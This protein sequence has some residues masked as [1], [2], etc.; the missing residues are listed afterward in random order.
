MMRVVL[1]FMQDLTAQRHRLQVPPTIAPHSGLMDILC[2][3]W[4]AP[5]AAPEMQYEAAHDRDGLIPVLL[6]ATDEEP[7]PGRL[8]VWAP[9]P[10]PVPAALEMLS[11]QALALPY[12]GV[13]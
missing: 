6:P 1:P 10:V 9:C 7:W 4:S 11:T 3:R 12:D 13:G 8:W 5:G 2:L